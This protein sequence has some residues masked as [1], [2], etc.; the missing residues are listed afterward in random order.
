MKLLDNFAAMSLD[1]QE[2]ISMNLTSTVKNHHPVNLGI[3]IDAH[4]GYVSRIEYESG[5]CML[6]YFIIFA[7]FSF[8]RFIH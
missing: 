4:Q 8:I 1:L 6:Y 5:D 3:K 7:A 2:R